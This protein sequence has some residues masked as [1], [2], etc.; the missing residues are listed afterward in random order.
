MVRYMAEEN[1]LPSDAR[2]VFH[3]LL[4]LREEAL[5]LDQ[6]TKIKQQFGDLFDLHIWITRQES[7][8]AQ[9]PEFPGHLN[10]HAQVASMSQQIGQP[11]DWWNTFTT[12]ALEHFTHTDNHN[13]SLVYICGPQALTDRLVDLYKLKGLST[14]DGHIQIEKWW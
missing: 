5:F 11:W 6:F 3:Y 10:I 14:Q 4:R 13:Q 2:I 1:V 7:D 12:K 9:S 8:V